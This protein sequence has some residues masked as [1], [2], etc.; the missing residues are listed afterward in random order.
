M[1]NG[2]TDF[3]LEISNFRGRVYAFGY[4]RGK[5]LLTTDKTGCTQISEGN[6]NTDFRLEISNFRNRVHTDSERKKIFNHE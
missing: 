6:G 4:G 5:K 2:N 3:R 1:G